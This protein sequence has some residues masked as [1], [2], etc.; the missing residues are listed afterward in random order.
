MS[1]YLT[2]FAFNLAQPRPFPSVPYIFQATHEAPNHLST[3]HW[4][5]T[6]RHGISHNPLREK[7]LLLIGLWMPSPSSFALIIHLDPH[8]PPHQSFDVHNPTNLTLGRAH[9]NTP[10][11]GI[12][13]K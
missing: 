2:C 6:H 13:I 9:M 10:V 1:P 8:N 12:P 4:M 7:A 3:T 5:L 11:Y